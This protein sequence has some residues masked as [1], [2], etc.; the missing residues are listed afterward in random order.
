MFNISPTETNAIKVQNK[1]TR[2]CVGTWTGTH[3]YH[4]LHVDRNT[5]ISCSARGQEHM[6]IM[7]C[8][9]NK[10]PCCRIHFA[11]HLDLV[12]S[13][14]IYFPLRLEYRAGGMGQIY[15]KT[16]N[17][18][19]RRYWCLIEFIDWRYSQSCLYFRA[20]LWTSAPL[21]FSLIHQPPP[22]PPRVGVN[23]Y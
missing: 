10:Y 13:C 22:P 7:L 18:K 3:V 2:Y 15:I 23:T 17:P 4:A 19:W 9:W 20:L 14:R 21:S 16:P 6:Y 11:L 1:N 12:P 5:C 8:T